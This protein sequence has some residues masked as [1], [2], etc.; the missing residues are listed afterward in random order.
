[1]QFRRVL[2]GSALVGV[3]ALVASAAPYSVIKASA[4]MCPSTLSYG[5]TATCSI[6]KA[7]KVTPFTL[8]A[9]A[10]DVIHTHV[11]SLTTDTIEA[12]FDVKDA[13]G[14]VLCAAR[15]GATTA[16]P[17]KAPA[18]GKYTINVFDAGADEM[19]AFRLELQRANKPVN[20]AALTVA[21]PVQTSFATVGENDWFTFSGVANAITVVRAAAIGSKPVQPDV[22]V[23]SPS[24]ELLCAS[25]AGVIAT[26]ACKTPVAGTYA[27]RVGDGSDNEVGGYA[28]TIRPECTING[29]TGADTINGTAGNDVIC[30]L[31]GADTIN[32]GDGDD[33]IIG[34][35]G[36]DRLE[37]G[38]GR[39]VFLME[40]TSDGADQVVGG[41]A[42]D[43]LSYA[44]R[45]NPISSDAD[46]VADDGEAKEKDDVRADVEQIIGGAGA[47]TLSGGA[48]N[49]AL[50]G[51]PG[52]DTLDGG[53]GT[54]SC[55]TGADGGKTANCE[56]A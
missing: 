31:A 46:V 1:M 37:G 12:D 41:Y 26:V 56:S 17:C 18:A 27:V 9:A 5:G 52:Y 15:A 54:D 7:G 45:T 16:M 25:R 51:G 20:A 6:D 34:G 44:E 35:T 10:G 33:I 13:A 21:S 22:D 43:T 47:D 50:F 38:N 32:G 42:I 4:A 19:G 40:R 23:F 28:L 39:D 11:V 29:T 8:T 30:G 3:A 53:A 36:N 2:R 14:K 48:V 49:N 24:G 55:I